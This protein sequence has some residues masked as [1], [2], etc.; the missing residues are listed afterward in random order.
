MG[1]TIRSIAFD[2]AQPTQLAKF[3]ADALTYTPGEEDDWDEVAVLNPPDGHGP[4][5]L[6]LKVPEGKMV[7]NRIHL[8]LHPSESME[9]EVERLVALGAYTVRV[10]HENPDDLFTVMQDPEGN[11]FCVAS[12]LST[13]R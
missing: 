11:E 12:P 8:D 7:K 5:M 13:E 6:F 9:A 3:W 10:V 1:A 4:R 2:C